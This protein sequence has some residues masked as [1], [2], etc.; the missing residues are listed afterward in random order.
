MHTV[1]VSLKAQPGK[2]QVIVDALAASLPDTRAY[3]GCKLVE[4]YVDE[5]DPD[6]II[7]WEK[8]DERASQGTYMAWRGTQTP[9]PELAGALAAA[10]TF[11]HYTLK[12]GV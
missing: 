12:P 11:V 9:S 6:T 5:D 4:T 3:A 2:G 1:I 10:P 8:W 7:L